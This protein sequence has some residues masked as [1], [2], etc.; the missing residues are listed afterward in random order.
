MNNL[1]NIFKILSDETRFRIL[2]LLKEESLCVCELCDILETAQPTISKNLSK[3]K[4]L[5]Y[6]SD[7]RK[8]KYV[9][10]EL[11]NIEL[12]NKILSDILDSSNLSPVIESDRKKLK[13]DS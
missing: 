4:D 12:L 1:I 11:N 2:L 9:F 13:D 3:L 8:D 10:Y 7:K 6:V 5:G